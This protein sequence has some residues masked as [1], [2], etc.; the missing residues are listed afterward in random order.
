MKEEKKV[1]KKKKG[2][3]SNMSEDPDGKTKKRGQ[4]AVDDER[5]LHEAY[6]IL[7]TE[8]HKRKAKRRKQHQKTPNPQGEL[9][10]QNKNKQEDEPVEDAFSH[11]RHKS[12]APSTDA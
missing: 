7:L 11:L 3:A 10:K 4:I 9:E 6:Q 12:L 2:Q 1:K 8:Y 5:Q